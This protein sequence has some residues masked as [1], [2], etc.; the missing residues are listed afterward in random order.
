MQSE[1]VTLKQALEQ[2]KGQKLTT[3]QFVHDYFQLGFEAAGLTAHRHPK[4][5]VAGGKFGWIDPHFR[6]ELCLLIETVVTATAAND[7]SVTICFESGARLVLP[8][9]ESVGYT[10]ESLEFKLEGNDTTWIA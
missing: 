4:L 7:D 5:Q 6:H 9:D 1:I 8:I 3:V 2:L 10:P